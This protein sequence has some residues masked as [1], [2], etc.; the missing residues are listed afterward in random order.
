MAVKASLE[1]MMY[2]TVET[3]VNRAFPVWTLHC[4]LCLNCKAFLANFGHKFRRLWVLKHSSVTQRHKCR[5]V[6]TPSSV[7]L[8]SFQSF[9]HQKKFTPHPSNWW[10]MIWDECYWKKGHQLTMLLN[11][12]KKTTCTSTVLQCKSVF[13]QDSLDEVFPLSWKAHWIAFRILL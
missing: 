8:K 2:N 3:D 13:F 4:Y 10:M 11:S 1:R 12:S 6:S 7:V 9:P 5:C